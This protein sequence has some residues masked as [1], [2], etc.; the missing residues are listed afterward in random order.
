MD[1]A[2]NQ[3]AGSLYIYRIHDDFWRY[4]HDSVAYVTTWTEMRKYTDLVGISSNMRKTGACVRSELDAALPRGPV[5]WGP[6]SLT[7]KDGL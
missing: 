6:W 1:F 5:G 7:P 2:V 3:R 4:S